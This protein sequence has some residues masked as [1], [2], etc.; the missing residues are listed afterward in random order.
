MTDGPPV[1]SKLNHLLEEL[2]AELAAVEGSG[3]GS[4]ELLKAVLGDIRA[5]LDE[6]GE[7]ES[8]PDGI[9][10]RLAHAR[11]DFEGSHPKV[12]GVLGRLIDALAS[13]G[14]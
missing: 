14:I 6:R 10:D 4:S 1:D 9:L 13:L 3:N 11:D 8:V 5:R 12:T 7:V 2:H